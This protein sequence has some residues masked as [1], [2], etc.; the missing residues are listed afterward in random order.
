MLM[1][2]LYLS[3]EPTLPPDSSLGSPRGAV[4]HGP[5]ALHFPNRG[6]PQLAATRIGFLSQLEEQVRVAAQPLQ[7]PG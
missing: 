1:M 6:L 2:M 4:E 5:G 3:E 7:S